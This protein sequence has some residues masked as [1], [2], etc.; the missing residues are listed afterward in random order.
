MTSTLL[1][2]STWTHPRPDCPNPE[3]WSAPDAYATEAEVTELVAAMVRALQP[4]FCIETGSWIGTTTEAIGR[5]LARNGHG[6]L[7]SLELDEAKAEQARV[8]CDGLPVT[9]L[10]QSSMAYTPDRPV[11]FAW[12][13]SEC[14]LRPLEFFRY[15]VAMHDRTV[16]GFH[17]TGPQH[18]VRE[19]LAP[20]ERDGTL[21]PLYLPTPRGVMFA[22]VNPRR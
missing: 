12:F 5:A 21:S 20:L 15:A 16:V 6:E 9:V 4:E 11:D 8:R 18:P 13:D 14:D 17:D 19:L 1:P 2:E 3:R 7:V 22:R 10:A